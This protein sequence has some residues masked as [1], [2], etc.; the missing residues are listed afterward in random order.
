MDVLTPY[1]FS[2]ALMIA[3][4]ACVLIGWRFG[5]GAAWR[6]FALGALTWFVAMLGKVVSAW[7]F[8]PLLLPILSENL[9]YAFY[10]VAGSIYIGALTGVFEVGF[11]WV[12][13]RLIPNAFRHRSAAIAV[14]VGA[15]AV[16][17][18]LLGAGMVLGYAASLGS[19]QV[20][21]QLSAML[22]GSYELNPVGWAIA[23]VERVLAIACH[24][25]SRALVFYG[26]ATGRGR[27]FWW[28]FLLL[29]AID[30]VAGYV[31]LSGFM[32][33]HSTWWVELALLPFAL[34]SIVITRA[35]YA[36][37]PSPSV[38]ATERTGA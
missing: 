14:G 37:W 10:M 4:A 36:T 38:S 20:H 32:Q 1:L 35:L 15:G 22:H 30:V 33:L 12:L 13:G 21:S 26:L 8:H 28:G 5:T 11:V 19:E 24:V 7:I 17:A 23:P 16:E 29:T 34:V 3:V 18:F 9:S 31:H 2:G 27:Y 25:G 6:W